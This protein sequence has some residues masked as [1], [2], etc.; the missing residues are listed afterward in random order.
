MFGT[1]PQ[2]SVKLPKALHSKLKKTAIERSVSMNALLNL[3]LL[4]LATTQA[5]A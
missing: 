5:L 1:G 4:L 3:A 2:T